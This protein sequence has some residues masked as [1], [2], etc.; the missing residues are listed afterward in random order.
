MCEVDCRLNKLQ[1]LDQHLVLNFG[2][3]SITIRV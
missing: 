3:I 1:N 2:F